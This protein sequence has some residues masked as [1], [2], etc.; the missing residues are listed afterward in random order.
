[1]N[2]RSDSSSIA[3]FRGQIIS[4]KGRLSYRMTEG[5]SL[6]FTSLCCAF[7]FKTIPIKTQHLSLTIQHLALKLE[8]L[9]RLRQT[10]I[11]ISGFQWWSNKGQRPPECGYLH[12]MSWGLG[13]KKRRKWVESVHLSL[14]SQSAE[15]KSAWHPSSY[16]N[17]CLCLVRFLAMAQD[18]TWGVRCEKHVVWQESYH[19]WV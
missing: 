11:L 1:M 2:P 8:S 10:W 3:S 14:S 19:E 4:C 7:S 6:G 12:P 13:Y 15:F 17:F 5:T 18:K 9:W 16:S